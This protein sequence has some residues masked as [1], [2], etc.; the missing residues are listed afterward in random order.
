M[1]S[2]LS[3]CGQRV[4]GGLLS[5]QMMAC[6]TVGRLGCGGGP[7]SLFFPPGLGQALRLQERISYHRH[8]RVLVEPGPGAA[9]EV[10]EP[11]L[12]FELLMSLASSMM[13]RADSVQYAS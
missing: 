6:L 9:L 4:G 10:V 7:A 8:E 13:A 11:E 3:Q 1:L 12:L 2:G 5:V